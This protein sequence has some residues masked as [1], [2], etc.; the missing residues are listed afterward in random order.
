MEE[1]ADSLRA[2]FQYKRLDLKVDAEG[3]I[4]TPDFSVDVSADIDPDDINKCVICTSVLDIK[5]PAAINSDAFAQ[6]FNGE[7]DQLC[8]E[9]SGRID[10]KALIDKVEDDA[11]GLDIDYPASARSCTITAPGMAG[12]CIEVNSSRVVI[13]FRSEQAVQALLGASQT[14]GQLA[15]SNGGLLGAALRLT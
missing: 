1:I 8:F 6:V 2:S 3:S 10:V 13:Q 5:N 9:V 12:A 15:A 14:F 4:E 11:R 7:F